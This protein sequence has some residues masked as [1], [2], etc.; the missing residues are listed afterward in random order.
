MHIKQNSIDFY[1]KVDHFLY[2]IVILQPGD[3]VRLY[4]LHAASYVP[5]N[6]APA[7]TSTNQDNGDTDMIELVLHRGTAY[8]RGLVVMKEYE[9]DVRVMKR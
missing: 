4:N 8:G 3:F 9:E 5:P 1:K 6:T 2:W 7:S